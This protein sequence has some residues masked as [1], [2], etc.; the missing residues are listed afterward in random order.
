MSS[1]QFAAMSPSSILGRYGA[2]PASLS[3]RA[4]GPFRLRCAGAARHA[5]SPCF[6]DM[7]LAALHATAMGSAARCLLL[8]ATL[9]IPL[10]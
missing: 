9:S 5:C 7:S 1:F 6:A 8:S 4:S 10:P 3:R 2:V